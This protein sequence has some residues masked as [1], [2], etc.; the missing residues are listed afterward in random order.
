[1][2]W[3]PKSSV[4]LEMARRKSPSQSPL[5]LPLSAAHDRLALL[6]RA[7][8]SPQRLAN[9]LEKTAAALEAGLAATRSYYTQTGKVSGNE[10][11]WPTRAKCAGLI[12]ELTGAAPSKS[13][14]SGAK[15][16]VTI[17][18][19]ESPWSPPRNVTPARAEPA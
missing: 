13:A 2:I 8:L 6:E 4:D 10:P 5:A 16:Q 19:A 7:Q 14:Q 11:D 17:A 18:P 15:V 12:I 9:L 3:A 1:M